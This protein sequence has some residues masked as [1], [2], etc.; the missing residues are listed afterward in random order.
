VNRTSWRRHYNT[1]LPHELLRYGPPTSEVFVLIFAAWLLA[2]MP[3][4]N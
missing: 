4:L 2:Q 3:K 1:I